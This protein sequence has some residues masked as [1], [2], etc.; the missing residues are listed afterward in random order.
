MNGSVAL[1][2]PASLP[3]RSLVSRLQFLG[4]L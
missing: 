2:P 3:A 4:N 1:L